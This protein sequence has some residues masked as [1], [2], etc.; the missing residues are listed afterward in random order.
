MLLISLRAVLT[1]EHYSMAGT[2]QEMKEEHL[3]LSRV[4]IFQ[5]FGPRVLAQHLSQAWQM[6][7]GS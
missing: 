7:K 3:P 1:S 2:N 5:M 4:L 6:Q